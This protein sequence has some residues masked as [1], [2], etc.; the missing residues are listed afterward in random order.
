MHREIIVSVLK[1]HMYSQS[2]IAGYFS[3]ASIW[4]KPRRDDWRMKTR[5]NIYHILFSQKKNEFLSF[6]VTWM[7]ITLRETSHVEN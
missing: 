2:T 5:V 6:E 3:T 1:E 7:V 4:N